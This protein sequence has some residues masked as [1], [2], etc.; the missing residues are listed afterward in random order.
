M[1]YFNKTL[2]WHVLIN[3][4]LEK[5]ERKKRQKINHM[6]TELSEDATKLKKLRVPE[7]NNYLNHHG[8]KQHLKSSNCKT[9]MPAAEES[10][11]S[12]PTLRNARTLTQNDNR[13]SADSSETD[14][15]DH[16]EYDSDAMDSGGEDDSSDVVLAFVNSDEEDANYRSNATRSEGAITRRSEIDFSFF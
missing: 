10:S 8:L 11:Q 16:D 1:K 3:E 6:R 4:V 13:A 15:S 14:E 12:W 7:V 5:R 9:F 2:K